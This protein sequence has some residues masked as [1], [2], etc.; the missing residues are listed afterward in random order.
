MQQKNRNLT[1]FVL[2]I[3]SRMVSEEQMINII[4]WCEDNF[5]MI[6]WNPS[7]ETV[8]RL[9]RL[10]AFR[11]YKGHIQKVQETQVPYGPASL[12]VYLN[13]GAHW[14]LCWPIQKLNFFSRSILLKPIF[15]EKNFHWTTFLVLAL[16]VMTAIKLCVWGPIWKTAPH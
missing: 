2:K 9:A 13:E 6:I 11:K 7:S 8:H 12:V 14:Y 1:F 15:S 4:I 5:F 10:T 16:L 3:H